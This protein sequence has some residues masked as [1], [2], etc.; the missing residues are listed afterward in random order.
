MKIEILPPQLTNNEKDKFCNIIDY[1]IQNTK[2]I[3]IMLPNGK[4]KNELNQNILGFL[5]LKDLINKQE[6]R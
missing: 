2:K 1:Y 5:V 3:T 6:A 4:L